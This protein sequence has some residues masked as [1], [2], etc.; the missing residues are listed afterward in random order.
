MKKARGKRQKSK[1]VIVQ[2][3]PV[4]LVFRGESGPDCS[5]SFSAVFDTY[6]GAKTY[7]TELEESLTEQHMSSYPKGHICWHNTKEYSEF[8]SY[9]CSYIR[10]DPKKK[11][12]KPNTYEYG[13]YPGEVIYI[14]EAYLH[15]NR[16]NRS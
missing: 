12:A 2:A 4:Y 7:A 8:H 9:R 14:L 1:D 16:S 10:F 13:E 5:P 3:K 6:E 11:G 15:E